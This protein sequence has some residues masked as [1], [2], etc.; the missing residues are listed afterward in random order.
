MEEAIPGL[1][2]LLPVIL[3]VGFPKSLQSYFYLAIVSENIS[4][5]DM[6]PQVFAS[7]SHPHIA[8]DMPPHLHNA[9]FPHLPSAT[10]MMKQRLKS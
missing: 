6:T 5:F 9:P 8:P 4:A 10:L 3:S 2:P 1:F 7:Q